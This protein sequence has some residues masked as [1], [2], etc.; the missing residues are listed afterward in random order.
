[1]V[2]LK[3]KRINGG[4]YWYAVKSARIN[5]KP[6]HGWQVYL[7]SAEKI[8]KIV[9]E[10]GNMPH[11]K[12]KSFEYGKI[13]ALLDINQDLGFVDIVDKYARKKRIHGLTAGEYMLLII[14]GRCDKP[15]SKNGMAKWFTNSCMGLLWKFSHKLSCQNFLNHMKRLDKVRKSVEDDLAKALI[16]KG[17]VPSRLIVDTSN[18][19]TYIEHGEKLPRK[20]KS[21]HHR[22]DKN[23]VALGLVVSEE[24]IPFISN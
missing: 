18:F 16:K 10:S 1:M 15:T 17:I 2:S 5:G 23:L 22:N 13:A 12:L 11:A 20:G 3:K 9:K 8:M 21:K 14:M 4:I 24:N 7:G 6:R 19:Y